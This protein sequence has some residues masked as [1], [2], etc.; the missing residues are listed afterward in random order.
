MRVAD[1]VGTF[2]K[3]ATKVLQCVCSV[4]YILDVLIPCQTDT[5]CF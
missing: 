3:R 1:L 2:G 5:D 4:T